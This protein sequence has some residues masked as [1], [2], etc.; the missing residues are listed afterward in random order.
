MRVPPQ[1]QGGKARAEGGGRQQVPSIPNCSHIP[2]RQTRPELTYRQHLDYL[3]AKTTSR[4]ASSDA[5][6]GPPG[7]LPQRHCGS[8]PR[9]LS[10]Q[11]LS[12]VLLSGVEVP[13]RNN[14]TPFSTAPC[15]QWL[16]VCVPPQSTS[17]PSSLVSPHLPSDVKQL[18]WR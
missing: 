2:R 5:W 6:P 18:F 13:T 9:H 1:Q 11:R 7:E 12:T 16:D 4:V 3:K 14:W 10:T 17:F 15:G 8:P